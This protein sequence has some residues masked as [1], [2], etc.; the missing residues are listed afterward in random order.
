MNNFHLE[1]EE[2]KINNCL[3]D[4]DDGIKINTKNIKKVIK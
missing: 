4:D 3:G 1:E 2:D